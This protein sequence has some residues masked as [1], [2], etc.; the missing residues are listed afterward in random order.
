MTRP[1]NPKS[2]ARSRFKTRADQGKR[3]P[4]IGGVAVNLR[5]EQRSGGRGGV[6]QSRSINFRATNPAGKRRSQ[7][8]NIFDQRKRQPQNPHD[9]T[10]KD[11]FLRAGMGLGTNKT[12]IFKRAGMGL[13]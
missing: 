4:P 13:T 8:F 5:A 7:P 9:P 2:K 3:F 12:K 1:L 11:P 10:S 6:P